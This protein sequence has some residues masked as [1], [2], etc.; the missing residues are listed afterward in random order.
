LSLDK[1]DGLQMDVVVAPPVSPLQPGSRDRQGSAPS[2][3]QIKAAD[4]ALS[5]TVIE[6]ER[7]AEISHWQADYVAHLRGASS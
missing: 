3:D 2:P 4:V 6:E 1:I 5:L 7:Y